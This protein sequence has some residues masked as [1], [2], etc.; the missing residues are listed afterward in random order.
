MICIELP[1][2]QPLNLWKCPN[3]VKVPTEIIPKPNPLWSH[4]I[5]SKNNYNLFV[6]LKVFFLISSML[7]QKTAPRQGS[8]LS[9]GCIPTGN[10]PPSIANE[11]FFRSNTLGSL[12]WKYLNTFCRIWNRDNNCL[13]LNLN[14]IA[15]KQ[16]QIKTSTLPIWRH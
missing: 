9:S 7:P 6:T 16:Q 11:W 12:S 3:Q 5:C 4:L 8:L 14:E 2:V 10:D 15:I 1:L 13:K